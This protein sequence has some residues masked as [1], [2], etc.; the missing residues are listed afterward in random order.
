MN[1]PTTD[2]LLDVPGLFLGHAEVDSSGVSVVVCPDG[3]VAAVDVRGGGPGT[4][5]TDL[6]APS[7]T[8]ESVHAVALCG[9]S[10][11]GLDAA[12]GVMAELEDRGIGLQVL[13]EAAPSLI[14]PI[15]PA[16]VI[17][18]L[19]VSD[20]PPGRPRRRAV[21]RSPTLSVTVP[22][23]GRVPPGCGPETSAPGSPRQPEP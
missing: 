20:P 5:E 19:P 2:T 6:L 7:N 3:A 12:G 8:V 15:V 13:G 1:E 9:G 22:W 4:R 11:F 23:T 21:G 16:A 17:F 10:A 14:V 18:D